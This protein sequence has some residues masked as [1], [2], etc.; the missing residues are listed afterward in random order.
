MRAMTFESLVHSERFA[1]ELLT[2][3]IGQ[4][5]LPRPGAVRRRGGGGTVEKTARELT[6]AHDLAK[7]ANAA[8]LL[9]SLAVPFLGLEHV[10]GATAILPD[11]A[12]IC[13]R[14]DPVTQEVAGSWLVMGDAKDYER[15]RSRIDDQRML[16][17]FLQ[18]ALGA[19]SAAVWSQLPKGMEVHRWG[20]LAVPRNAFLQPEAVVERLDDHRAEVATRAA[21]RMRAKEQL[22]DDAPA[23]D[24]LA[25]YVEHLQATFHPESCVSCNLFSY[26]RDELRNSADPTALLAEIGIDRLTR[27]ALAGLVEGTGEVG[28]VAQRTIAQVDATLSGRAHL[29]GRLR[30]DPCAEPGTINLVLVKS[31]SSAIGVHGL[32]VQ[33]ITSEGAEPWLRR[34]FSEPQSPLTRRVIMRLVGEAIRAVIDDG[35]SPVQVVVPDRPTADLLVTAAD[36]MAGVELSRLRW[37]QDL[38]SGR[39]ALTFNAEPATLPEPLDDD[40]RLAVSFL[41]EE[42]RARALSLRA[43]IVDLRTV[44]ATHVIAGGP[45]VE[46]GRLDYLL[47]W[48]AADDPVDHRELSDS[49]AEQVDTPGARLSNSASDALFLAQRE[50]T[51]SPDRYSYLVNEALDYRISVVEQTLGILAGYATSRLRDVYRLLESDA[52]E[53]WRRRLALQASDLVRF[54]RTYPYWRAAQVELLDADQKCCEQL[55]CIVDSEVA[56][57]KAIQAGVREL[58]LATVIGLDPIRLDVQSRRLV[59]GSRVVALHVNERALIEDA[60]TSIQ[61]QKGSFK[62]GQLAVAVLEE[63]A[64]QEGLVWSPV[65]PLRNLD[66]GDQLVLAETAWFGKDLTSGHQIA[67][68]RP[69]LDRQAAPRVTCTESTFA[70]D[71]VNHQWCCKPHSIAEAEWSDELAARRE[72]GELNPDT[73]PPLV[74]EDRFDV[75]PSGDEPLIPPSTAPESLTIDDLD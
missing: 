10:P 15:V 27:R 48:V 33:R 1:S 39:P 34:V 19:E 56:R 17:G 29:T 37:Q 5:D 38:D 62:L 44:L 49:I 69:S 14:A 35:T 28:E 26:C 40:E 21:E 11:F 61:V 43:P 73:W 68:A 65:V 23:A 12:I 45:A 32:A 63:R 30:V 2:K 52:Q 47:A 57:D 36:S 24:D 18:V 7:G 60:G 74:D 42:D 58:A 50:T 16:K 55:S 70:D 4:L 41:L 71:P 20:A 8:T 72:R 59:H 13:S 51:K 31:D 25:D 64:G 6:A 22:G 75:G 54:S 67:V 66:V 53:V 46:S 9:T 3:A